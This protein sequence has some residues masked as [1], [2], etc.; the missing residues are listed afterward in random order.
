[1]P[2]L[3]YSFMLNPLGTQSV[4]Q[5]IEQCRKGDKKAEKALYKAFAQ[6]MFMHA[7]RYLKNKSDAEEVLTDAFLKVFANLR[8]LEYRDEKSLEAWIRKIVINE[9]LMFLRKRKRLCYVDES[10]LMDMES[11]LTIDNE[12][13]AEEVYQLILS[14]P[15]GYR[16]V[17]NLHAIEG[18]SH[19]EIALQLEITESTSRSQLTKARAMLKDLWAKNNL[20][21]G[22]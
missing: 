6:K 8:T 20:R 3:P 18:Y 7:Y 4:E 21:Y 15:D 2:A 19:K 16:T 13:A 14:L 12:L 5:T 10:A 1:M 17:F 9:A 11:D 22:A